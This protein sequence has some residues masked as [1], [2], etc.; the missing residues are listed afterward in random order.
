MP[1]VASALR[2]AGFGVT[3]EPSAPY[4]VKV[5]FAGGGFDLSCTIVMFERGVAIASGKG[6]NPGFGVWLARDKAYYGVF[7]DA[8]SQFS[9]RIAGA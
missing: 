6:V 3:A 5:V 1:E 4:H 8:L 2:R 7:Q 9:R